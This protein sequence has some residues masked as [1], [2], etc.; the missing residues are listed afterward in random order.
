MKKSNSVI[1]TPIIQSNLRLIK[2]PHRSNNK[3]FMTISD[4]LGF[5]NKQIEKIDYIFKSDKKYKPKLWQKQL[6][7]NIYKLDGKTNYEIL[8]EYTQ[9]F[10]RRKDINLT[11]LDLSK[12][13][14]LNKF[15]SIYF[16]L[17]HF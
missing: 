5:V 9:K 13:P 8:K 10:K 16:Y 7:N 17:K 3:I 4:D 15:Y 11:K 2:R 12:Q 1:F 6:T 14:N